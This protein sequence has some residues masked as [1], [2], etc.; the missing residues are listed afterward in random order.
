MG[1]RIA[2]QPSAA[3]LIIMLSLESIIVRDLPRHTADL[4]MLLHPTLQDLEIMLTDNELHG[5]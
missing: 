2:E 4:C 3:R 1:E 5:R